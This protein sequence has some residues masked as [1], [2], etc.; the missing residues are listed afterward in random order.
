MKAL[1]PVEESLVITGVRQY[2]I[3]G[4]IQGKITK[5]SYRVICIPLPGLQLQV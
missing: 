1:I 2:K 5:P 4:I 3:A